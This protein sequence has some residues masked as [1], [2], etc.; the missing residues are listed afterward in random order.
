MKF[1]R[2]EAYLKLSEHIDYLLFHYTELSFKLNIDDNMLNILHDDIDLI[3]RFITNILRHYKLNNKLIL[4]ERCYYSHI[5]NLRMLLEG[6]S[7]YY[8]FDFL[9]SLFKNIMNDITDFLNDIEYYE[10]SKIM[11]IISEEVADGIYN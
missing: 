9:N 6:S 1:N 10:A 4:N 5:I 7:D 11:L 3:I 8:D 2:E